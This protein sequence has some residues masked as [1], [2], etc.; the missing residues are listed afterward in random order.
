MSFLKQ[1]SVAVL[2]GF[3]L[4]VTSACGEDIPD[5]R[6]KWQGDYGD[7]CGLEV[8][9]ITQEAEN[10]VATKV[11][12]DEYVPAGQITWRASVKTGAGEG[13]VAG[14]GFDEPRFV[15]GELKII[16]ESTIRFLWYEIG[17][18]EYR[19]LSE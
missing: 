2:S 18:I 14:I 4:A 16:D 9:M 1:L 19:R 11:T 3:L 13:Q 7:C 5:L 8:I 10:A 17:A 12:G 6:G 15:L